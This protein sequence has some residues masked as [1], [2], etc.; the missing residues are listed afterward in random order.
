MVILKEKLLGVGLTLACG[1]ALAAPTGMNLDEYLQRVRSQNS[2]FESVELS[3]EAAAGRP[4]LGDLELSPIFEAKSFYSDDQTPPVVAGFQAN[5]TLVYGGAI[6]LKKQFSTG[7]ALTLDYGST[8]TALYGLPVPYPARAW[9]GLLG[10]GFRQSLWKNGF[11][12]A[13][14]K[15]RERE[16]ATQHLERLG[17]EAKARQTL[18]DAEAAYWDYLFTLEDLAQKKDALSR[19]QRL[20]AWMDRRLDDGIADRSDGLQVKALYDLRRLELIGAEDN[21]KAARRKVADFL[22]VTQVSEV[23]EELG[24]DISTVRDPARLADNT[25]EPR[26]ID[27]LL[28]VAEAKMRAAVASE[29]GDALR[30]DLR[31]EGLVNLNSKDPASDPTATPSMG[32]TLVRFTDPLKPKVQMQL[33]WQMNLDQGGVDRALG[34]SRAEAHAASVLAERA[35]FES[36]SAWSELLRRHGELTARVAVLE[37]LSKTQL[38]KASREQERLSRG[39]TTTFQVVN[40]EQEAADARLNLLRL[41]AEQRKLEAAG[42]LFIADTEGNAP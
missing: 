7:T 30:S 28:K 3:R 35:L 42:R 8:R 17:L 21:L 24:T 15:R 39:R 32:P 34:V 19:A 9:S 25:S 31:L 36:K 14:R 2:V 23:P 6:G 5:R 13:T 40:F 11:G 18:V 16:S 22:Q 4:E 29:T 1:S 33:V 37:S 26:R 41:K 12:S 20:K 38:E 10:V 27:T